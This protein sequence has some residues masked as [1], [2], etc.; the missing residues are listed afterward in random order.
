MKVVNEGMSHRGTNRAQT[1]AFEVEDIYLTGEMLNTLQRCFLFCFHELPAYALE[2]TCV[3][4]EI[5]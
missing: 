3:A 5:A 4:H 2:F 1:D